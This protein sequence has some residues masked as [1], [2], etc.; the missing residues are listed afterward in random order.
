MVPDGLD[1]VG[2]PQ[3][4]AQQLRSTGGGRSL[5]LNG[6]IDAVSYKPLERWTS[7]PLEPE[8][9]D[10]LL[11]GRGSCDMKGGIAGMLFA[12]ETV[13]RLGAGSPATSSSA[14]HR[15]GVK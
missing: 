15:R 8:V 1:F 10:G 9:R 6:H 2:R 5:L 14:R 3:L 13:K 12:L 11:Y 4:A 7:H